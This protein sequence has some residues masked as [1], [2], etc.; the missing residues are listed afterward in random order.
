MDP[1][2]VF[3][4]PPVRVCIDSV[5][6]EVVSQLENKAHVNAVG[7]WIDAMLK[8]GRNSRMP[9]FDDPESSALQPAPVVSA[10]SPST[11]KLRA[12]APADFAADLRFSST[13]T[14]GKGQ[15]RNT[16]TVTPAGANAFAA[17][18]ADGPPSGEGEGRQ[19]TPD[20]GLRDA[21]DDNDVAVEIDCT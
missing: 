2:F 21:L 10:A 14:Y 20:S 12:R 6:A 18:M 17:I 4:G 3:D 5:G 13:E 7:G 1:D 15:V 16:P 19:A 9:N 11:E 8:L